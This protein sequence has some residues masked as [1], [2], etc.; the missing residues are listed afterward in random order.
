MNKYDIN[1]QIQLDLFY[2]ARN[3]EE[4][5][6]TYLWHVNANRNRNWSVNSPSLNEM[7]QEV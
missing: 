6:W 4:V 1:E 3:R 2:T 5:V 7:A